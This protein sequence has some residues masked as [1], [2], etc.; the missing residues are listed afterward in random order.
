MGLVTMVEAK[1]TEP[2]EAVSLTLL[3]HQSQNA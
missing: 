3:A 2:P 1:V